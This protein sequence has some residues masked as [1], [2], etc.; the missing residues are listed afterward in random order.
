MQRL[1]IL[2]VL[3]FSLSAKASPITLTNPLPDGV[4]QARACMGQAGAVQEGYRP[5]ISG[6]SYG[7]CIATACGD[8]YDLS[9][10]K[11]RPVQK[12]FFQEPKI[13]ILNAGDSYTLKIKTNKNVSQGELAVT[14]DNGDLSLENG[15]IVSFAN[16]NFNTLQ[17]TA[18]NVTQE[19]V[20]NLTLSPSSG[21]IAV[22]SNNTLVV[23]VEPLGLPRVLWL[24]P[25]KNPYSTSDTAATVSIN[26]SKPLSQ[27][28][29][30]KL[31]LTVSGDK[32]LLQNPNLRRVSLVILK[33]QSSGSVS[34]GLSGQSSNASVTLTL[35]P[36]SVA[37]LDQA[38]LPTSTS[39]S[40]QNLTCAGPADPSASPFHA[41]VPFDFGSGPESASLIC[42]KA[43]LQGIAT[44]TSGGVVTGNYLIGAD[45]DMQSEATGM[46]SLTVTGKIDG[47]GKTISHISASMAGALTS[48]SAFGFGFVG[49][50]KGSMANLT[51]QN[52]S[53]SGTS[54]Y[55]FVGAM[56]GK[57]MGGTISN[58]VSD[59]NTL[60][61]TFYVG[62]LVG[63]LVDISSP[64]AAPGLLQAS[65]SS[66]NTL[67]SLG[68]TAMA[69]GAAGSLSGSRLSS[70][71]SNYNSIT[72]QTSGQV[73]AYAASG[74]LVGVMGGGSTIE[75]SSSSSNSI[76]GAA[77]GRTHVAGGLVGVLSG[78]A[79]ARQV[80][81]SSSSNN[82]I[83][84]N[85]T[86]S[87][88]G[89]VGSNTT[90]QFN[91]CSVSNTSVVGT[92]AGIYY[93]FN[94]NGSYSN[95]SYDQVSVNGTPQ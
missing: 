26:L 52:S 19:T 51:V 65:T 66:Y 32:S 40:V 1:G 80:N 62:G 34:L 64:S 4:T 38:D 60:S 29:S 85:D 59:H 39:I 75:N 31:N 17:I 37:K 72:T 30:T 33:G 74:G 12:A 86:N 83:G 84:G 42:S 58:C 35:T 68:K 61:G 43:E 93:G 41:Q 67:S 89:L 55:I 94:N 14:S 63:Q 47:G 91:S 70:V 54:G 53:F 44:Q 57:T 23:K 46:E 15:G 10:D 11:C 92:S 82:S 77:N 49:T 25:D 69:G 48:G 16:Q 79:L 95:L 2:S 9:Q 22:A 76:S 24:Q 78:N 45:I 3:L 27:T 7:A 8:G 81:S 18:P 5:L 20:F 21:K 56:A 71:T 13:L 90:G 88:G 87:A 73:G 6:H 36:E 50:L 28:A